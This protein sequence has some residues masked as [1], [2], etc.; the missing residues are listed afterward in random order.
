MFRIQYST[1][2][3]IIFHSNSGS[4]V[5]QARYS[6]PYSKL[7]LWLCVCVVVFPF[8]L[9]YHPKWRQ[10]G[11]ERKKLKNQRKRRLSKNAATRLFIRTQLFQAMVKKLFKII[12]KNFYLIF[13]K[14]LNQFFKHSILAPSRQ[15]PFWA[16]WITKKNNEEKYL[17]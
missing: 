6:L 4:F 10:S 9:S 12:F 3:I 17:I 5:S 2:F 15:C 16:V 14:F 11:K 7:P 1:S 8:S 13:W